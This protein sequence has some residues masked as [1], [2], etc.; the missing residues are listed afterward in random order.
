MTE[1]LFVI[2]VV[3]FFLSVYGVVMVGSHLL[4]QIQ[5]DEPAPL[6]LSADTR[7]ADV[8]PPTP[9]LDVVADVT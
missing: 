8:V 1:V 2:G 7:D 5:L 6:P 3:V 4:E 9:S